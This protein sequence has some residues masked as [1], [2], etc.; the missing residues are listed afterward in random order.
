VS[1]NDE[2]LARVRAAH[3]ALRVV[4]DDLPLPIP[5]LYEPPRDLGPDRVMG[6]VGAL[7]RYPDAPA[8]LLVDL[9][10]CLTLTLG[11]RGEGILGGAILPGLE[12]QARALA[13]WTSR[14][15][16]VGPQEPAAAL[17]RSTEQSIRSGVWH[18]VVGAARELIHRITEQSA[19]PPR[20]VAAGAG[21]GILGAAIPSVD[22]VHPHATLWGV[23]V[24]A[25]ST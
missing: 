5:V 7:H 1:V 4:G 11:V 16:R 20:V 23:Y 13:E 10:T 3:P 24:T 17:G 6:V 12:L 9:G 22:S 14:L 2:E 21:A 15:P 8:V 18:G 19:V 25:S